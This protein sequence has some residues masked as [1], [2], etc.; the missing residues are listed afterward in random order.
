[1]KLSAKILVLAFAL[2]MLLSV[3]V[4]AFNS[5]QTYTYS[6]NGEPLHSPDA[7][8]PIPGGVYNSQTMELPEDLTLSDPYDMVVD[9]DLNVY[10]VD[11]ATNTV[12]VLDRYYKYKFSIS[13]FTN[14]IGAPDGF[15]SPRGI[16]VTDNKYNGYGEIVE[17]GKIYVCDTQK[18]RIVVFDR[19]GNFLYVLD[20]PES[21]LFEEGSVYYPVAV[22]VDQYNRIYVVSTQTTQGII[23]LTED[24]Q[25]TGFIGAQEVSISLWDIIWKRFQ[26]DEQRKLTS[27]FVPVTFSNITV[28]DEG[29]VYATSDK[30]EASK[31]E[32]A[33]RSKTGSASNSPV[34]MLNNAGSEIMRRNGFYP[35]VGE[36]AY[37][38]SSTD[39]DA[40]LGVS[41]IGDVAIGEAGT[42]SMT[43]TKR[44][45]VF[46]YDYD[47]NLLFAFGDRGNLQLGNLTTVKAIAYQG[48]LLLLLDSGSSK[49][50]TVYER[51]EYGKILYQAVSDQ[52]NRQ[53]DKAIDNWTEIL[54]RNSNF[55]AAYIGIG[56]ALYRSGQY[57]AALEQYK[58]AY[59]TTNYST[60]YA[61]IRK[62]TIE[63]IFILIPVVIIALC[64]GVSFLSKKISKVNIR[65][66][67][68][69]EKI[70]FGKELLYGFHV[71]AHPFDGFWD[72]KHEKRGS[73][74]ASLV[75][76]AVTILAFYYQAIGQGYLFNPQGK[77]STVFAQI[78]GVLMPV[79]LFVTANWCLTTL[80]EGEGS[81]RDVFVATSY[82][83][84][85]LPLFI[86]PATIVSNFVIAT[87]MDIVNL[88]ISF[89]FI[90]V[91]FLLVFGVQVTHDYSL[92]KNIITVIGSI[93]G[94]VFIMFVALLFTTL[95]GKIIGFV[96]NIF[97]EIGYRL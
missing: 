94:M 9:D 36:I 21:E 45:K 76:I 19:S 87:E 79:M 11:A 90:W 63:K 85:P 97:I 33:I 32:S 46:T 73:V 95:L 10:I 47:G 75:Y 39:K 2:V 64:L 3:P 25:F 18:Y 27:S 55:D 60:S 89:A 84:V 59:D 67:T 57:E 77:Y 35:P 72:L 28:N 23:V 30:I 56:Q 69:G 48:D 78:V 38:S 49:S 91:G 96:S 13:S 4:S 12:I 26:T 70:T 42:W 41:T 6:I 61:E 50:I 17:E 43:D 15:A 54:M 1:M 66:A 22:A 86:I 16:F 34:K 44:S 81:F 7:Y 82:A 83:L 14:E 62:Q 53:Y 58:A 92:G 51:T 20:A 8:I 68:S 74:R 71:M 93:A 80:F 31:V 40:V 5:F 29:F 88:V 24:G 65:A 37:M 52:I